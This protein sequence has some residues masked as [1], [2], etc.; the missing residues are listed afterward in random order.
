LR[1]KSGRGGWAGAIIWKLRKGEKPATMGG[2]TETGGSPKHQG[3][4]TD[5]AI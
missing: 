1:L 4:K 5:F 2:S 3:E